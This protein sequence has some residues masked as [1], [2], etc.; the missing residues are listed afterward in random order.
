MTTLSHIIITW[1]AVN[2]VV[3]VWVLTPP[4]ALNQILNLARPAGSDS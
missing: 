4:C 1:L 3:V 2:S